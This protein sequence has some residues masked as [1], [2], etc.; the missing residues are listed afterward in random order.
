MLLKRVIL[1]PFLTAGL[2]AP[3]YAQEANRSDVELSVG[4]A[5]L[6]TPAFKGSDEYQLIAVPNISLNYK[7]RLFASVQEGL[8]YNL[9]NQ[10]GWRAGPLLR[11]AFERKEDGSSTFRVAG[12]KSD[13]LR[14]L[15]DVDG[16]FEAG[17]F[18]EYRYQEWSGKVELRQGINGHEG[19]I[20]DVNAN[21]TKNIAPALN[22]S[23]RPVIL[24]LGPRA[25][26]VS[27]D[28]NQA[29]YGVNA[30]QSAASGLSQY[31]AEG[32]LLS[33]GAGAA[34]IIPITEKVSSTIFAGYDRLSGDAGDSPLVQERGS[35]DQATAGVSLS[36]KFGL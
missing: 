17:G 20:A 28:Y 12:D 24:S 3:A 32:G 13:A 2:V 18:L 6:V 4:A 22:I 26:F 10:N 27:D 14:G 9:V 23:D 21:Y 36:Y 7:D 19:V 1:I 33:Y 29:Y 30:A 15:G 11:Y 5:T 35:E 34:T 31:D 16:T 8:G 25:T